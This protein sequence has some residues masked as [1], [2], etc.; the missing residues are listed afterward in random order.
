MFLNH[1]NLTLKK[2]VVLVGQKV[3]TVL[4][5]SMRLIELNQQR[6]SPFRTTLNQWLLGEKKAAFQSG[7]T[8]AGK[9][10]IYWIWVG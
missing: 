2:G 5:R 3:S 4:A 7:G 9:I 10:Q 6:A 8:E 1:F